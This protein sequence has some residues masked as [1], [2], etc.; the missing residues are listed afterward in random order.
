M[1][2]LIAL[3]T[4]VMKKCGGFYYSLDYWNLSYPEASGIT[5]HERIL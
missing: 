2:S 5:L 3:F 4:L 1:L